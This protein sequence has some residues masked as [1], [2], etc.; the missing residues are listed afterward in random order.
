MS[1]LREQR[2]ISDTG[3]EVLTSVHANFLRRPSE[4]LCQHAQNL[5]P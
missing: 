4:D 5:V 1:I 3:F 2:K